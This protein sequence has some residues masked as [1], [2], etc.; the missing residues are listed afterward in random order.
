MNSRIECRSCGG[1]CPVLERINSDLGEKK[2]EK[3]IKKP[4]QDNQYLMLRV[5]YFAK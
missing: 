1:H 2:E 4:S 5:L 3:K